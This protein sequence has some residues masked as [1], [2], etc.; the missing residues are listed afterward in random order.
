M[1][2]NKKFIDIHLVIGVSSSVQ[3]VYLFNGKFTVKDQ[4]SGP[5]IM[6]FTAHRCD[7]ALIN[8]EQYNEFKF[9]DI[10]QQLTKKDTLW[11]PFVKSIH[12]KISFPFV[13][14]NYTVDDGYMDFTF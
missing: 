14:G 12:P 10:C 3:N 1:R 7:M 6:V 2:C 4:V 5:L 11:A 8:C 9:T 13:R